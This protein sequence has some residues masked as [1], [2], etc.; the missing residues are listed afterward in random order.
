M[1]LK[2]KKN[3]KNIDN[4]YIV[5]GN[6][7]NM[8]C[9]HCTQVPIKN[10]VP[11]KQEISDGVWQLIDNF[12]SYAIRDKNRLIP[13]CLVLWGGEPLV[14]W[15][16]MKEIIIRCNEKFNL[17]EI[18]WQQFRIKINTNGTLLDKEKIDFIN[19]YG[20]RVVLSYDVPNPF[21]VRGQITDAQCELAQ[22]IKNFATLSS[23][24]G[25][26]NDYF[27]GL[28]CIQKKFPKSRHIFNYNLWHTSHMDSEIVQYSLETASYN[29]KKLIL[30]ARIG[31]IPASIAVSDILWRLHSFGKGEF[32]NEY[33]FRKCFSGTNL[34]SVKL[35]GEVLSCYNSDEP[36]GTVDSD[37]TA[38]YQNGFRQYLTRRSAACETCK[39]N[40]IC[41]GNCS[42]ALKNN[43]N[44]FISCETYYI[45]MYTAIK[46]ELKK[47]T[48]PITEAEQKWFEEEY[49]KDTPYVDKF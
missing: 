4:L 6:Q 15:N 34:Y 44:K 26:N 14:Y 20:V 7:C 3:F 2:D 37:Q 16:T 19:K 39:H 33:F 8:C 23:F 30:A 29:F 49:E 38:I 36:V 5:M 45:P 25:I 27:L 42:F 35:N 22:T 28:R 47:I 10:N 46:Q 9:R 11:Q 41:I 24:N 21:A 17:Q 18:P 1:K 31:H 48:L 43:D 12:I 13:R 32:F 40:D